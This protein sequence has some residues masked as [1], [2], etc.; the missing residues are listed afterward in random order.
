MYVAGD[1][2]WATWTKEAEEEV[3]TSALEDAATREARRVETL[4]SAMMPSHQPAP[5]VRRGSSLPEFKIARRSAVL[6]SFKAQIV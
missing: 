1:D 6:F 5:K 2:E 3:R 4:L